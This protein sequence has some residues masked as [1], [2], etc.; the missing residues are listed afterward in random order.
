[1]MTE[2]I[3]K[4]VHP[5]DLEAFC[6]LVMMK[7]GLTEDDARISAQVMVTNDTWGIYTHGTRQLRYLLRAV[8]AGRLDPKAKPG[9][10]EEGPGWTIV[11][12]HHAFPMVTATTGMRTAIDKAKMNGIAY[13]GVRGSSHFGAAGYYANMAMKEDLIGISVSNADPIMTIPGA[14]A[15]IFGTNPFSYAIPAGKEKPV[16]L[17]IA[18]STVAAT[19]VLAAQ[20]MGKSIPDNWVVNKEGLPTTDPNDFLAGGAMVP[21]AGH[22]GYGM[23]LL[24]EVLAAVMTGAAVTQE[25]PSWVKEQPN[26]VNQGHAFI[27]IDVGTIMPIGH[28]KQRMDHMIQEIKS[29][30]KAKGS[31]RIY[32]PGEMEWERREIA[33]EKGME[34]P[35]H[36][37]LSLTET[38][39]DWG[40]EAEV[41][42]LL[43]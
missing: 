35:D 22:K 10:A 4:R 6:R 30:P 33:L 23:A 32:L 27:A 7:A 19:K 31:D 9:I 26:P 11:D 34:L 21:M 24:I 40:L 38:A 29:A 12:G 15:R 37:V 36:V 25:M 42:E 3:I 28:F 2:T 41:K 16:F 18:V 17:D 5:L 20:D 13:T 43:S 8:R 1:M 14:S 39:E